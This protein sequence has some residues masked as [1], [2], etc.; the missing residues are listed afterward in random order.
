MDFPSDENAEV[1]R[2]MEAAG[3]DLT[4]SRNI[5]F[6]V[7]FP[8]Q[9]AAQ[10]FAAR[11]RDL[12]FVASVELTQTAEDHPWDVVVVKNMTPSREGIGDF[13]NLLESVAVPLGGRNDGWGCMSERPVQES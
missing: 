9:A 13:E 4:L 1:L 8:D 11:I 10:K 2:R 5:D 3:D 7:V 6:T 12:G